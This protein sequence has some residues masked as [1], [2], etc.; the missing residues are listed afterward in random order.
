MHVRQNAADILNLVHVQGRRLTLRLLRAGLLQVKPS[1]GSGSRTNS[2]VQVQ[3]DTTDFD[4]YL[5]RLS[6]Y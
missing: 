4:F 2:R 5:G 1:H 3:E 6:N